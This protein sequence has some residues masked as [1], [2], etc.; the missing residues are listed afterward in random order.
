V[1]AIA[2][3]RTRTAV[4]DAAGVARVTVFPDRSRDVWEVTRYQVTTTS[5][6]GTECTVYRGSEH[7]GAQVD[8]TRTGNGD[9]SEQFHPV[10][11]DFGQPL[12]F[13]W[14]GGTPGAV[15]TVSIL[16]TVTKE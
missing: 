1:T 4:F 8:F 10:R 6:A 2:L 11:V 12:V 5:T 13:V 9:T 16:G 3:D 15:A 14:I 7:S